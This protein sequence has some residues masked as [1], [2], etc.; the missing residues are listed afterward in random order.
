[1]QAVQKIKSYFTDRE[2]LWLLF[3]LAAVGIA[4][5]NVWMP[6]DAFHSHYTHYNNFEIF[7]YSFYHLIHNQNLY[8]HYPDQHFDLYKYSPTFALVFGAFAW[9]P[10]WLGL[11]LWNLLNVFVLVAA[12]RSLPGL[13]HKMQLGM[14]LLLIQETITSTI[15]S[16]CNVLIAGLLILAWTSFE[17]QKW[18]KGILLI[19]VTTFIKIFGILFFALLLFYPKWW[20]SILPASLIFFLLLLLPL[21]ITGASGLLQQYENWFLL[22][23]GDGETFVK[24]SVMGW[25]QSWFGVH[26]SKPVV[27]M[28]GLAIQMLPLVVLGV[29]KN[30]TL[31]LRALYAGSWMIWLVIFNHM[32][33][34]ATFIIAVTGVLVWFYYSKQS[35]TVKWA[36]LLPVIL[37]TCFGP[38]DIYP[39]EWRKLIVEE[40]Q[41]KVFPC[42]L[43]WVACIAE[44]LAPAK[45]GDQ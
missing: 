44:L 8:I 32:A 7:K 26:P 15:N 12:I 35:N 20:K 16:Q 41:L 25:I 10:S 19:W 23:K 9:L 5:R 18:R 42:I 45:T 40:W 13:S 29:R 11:T 30:S 22:L 21:P 38:S 24:Y 1:M 3:G 36:L 4:L 17:A 43:V 33:E 34:S 14:G 6:N 31:P 37:F 39:K 2:V 28:A 27:L